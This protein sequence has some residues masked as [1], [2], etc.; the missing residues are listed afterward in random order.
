MGYANL[1]IVYLRMGEFEEA[2]DWLSKA[3]KMEPEDPDV[4]LILAKVYEMSGNSEK[5]IEEL[6]KIM[7]FLAGTCEIVI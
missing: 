3:I 4:R 5:A 7:Q 6:E 1:G 2:G